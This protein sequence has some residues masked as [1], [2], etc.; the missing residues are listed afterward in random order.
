MGIMMFNRPIPLIYG[1]ATPSRQLREMEDFMDA[2]LQITKVP[3]IVHMCALNRALKKNPDLPI[4]ITYLIEGEEEI[5]S[6]SF[7]LFWKQI[8]IN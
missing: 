6:P 2:V 3:Q 1:Q 7:V 8:K 4:H 5:G